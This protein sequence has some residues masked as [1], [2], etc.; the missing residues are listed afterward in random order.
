MKNL[1]TTSKGFYTYA[2]VL[3]DSQIDSLIDVVDKNIDNARD[4]IL[5]GEFSINPKQIGL[6]KL[7]CNF[8]KYKDICYRTNNDFV[9]LKENKS[10]SFLGGE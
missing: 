2:K 1:K 3:T 8:C 4:N 9:K 5:K 7:G 6:E 10:L